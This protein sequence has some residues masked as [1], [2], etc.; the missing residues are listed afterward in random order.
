MIISIALVVKYKTLGFEWHMSEK[1]RGMRVEIK[2]S[3]EFCKGM[4]SMSH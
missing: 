2:G 1:Y 4:V 3:V